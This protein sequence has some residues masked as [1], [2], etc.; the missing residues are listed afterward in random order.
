MALTVLI[1][2]DAGRAGSELGNV[3][4]FICVTDRFAEQGRAFTIIRNLQRKNAS[5]IR[6]RVATM[7]ID[8]TS[9]R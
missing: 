1:C 2:S 9:A 3:H 5:E 8:F 4:E 7:C 6:N